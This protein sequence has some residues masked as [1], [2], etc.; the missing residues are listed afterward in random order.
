MKT[1]V[2]FGASIPVNLLIVFFEQGVEH[3][4]IILLLGNQIKEISGGDLRSKN[5][6]LLS[7]SLNSI[8]VL[9]IG[10]MIQDAGCHFGLQ[11]A[12]QVTC[13]EAS[14][15]CTG[16]N[17]EGD[18][19]ANERREEILL[20]VG[21]PEQKRN[22]VRTTV[23][24]YGTEPALCSAAMVKPRQE[25][26]LTKAI[27]KLKLPLYWDTNFCCPVD[28]YATATMRLAGIHLFNGLT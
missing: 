28:S 13:R 4:F 10:N 14:G 26:S 23:S 21:A 6:N 3:R 8:K 19:S 24:C 16:E 22:Y 20:V 1:T 17:D 9:L 5:G 12:L 18:H 25:Y 2:C 15:N 11:A 7:F 27:G